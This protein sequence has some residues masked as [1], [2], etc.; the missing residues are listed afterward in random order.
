MSIVHPNTE[1]KTYYR[2][3]QNSLSKY[4]MDQA[5]ESWNTNCKFS[6][7]CFRDNLWTP[8]KRFKIFFHFLL[9]IPF[10]GLN[11]VLTKK[12]INLWIYM[13][14]TTTY[15]YLYF[16]RNSDILTKNLNY[17]YI[18]ESNTYFDSY[19]FTPT[20]FKEFSFFAPYWFF[21]L[22]AQIL[23]AALYLAISSKKSICALKKK[24]NLCAKLSIFNFSSIKVKCNLL[25][26]PFYTEF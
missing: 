7:L 8:Q 2:Y 22:F 19:R 25:M 11:I 3:K 15:Y 4:I 1:K 10:I 23:L 20:R 26:I 5:I 13:V 14:R 6:I 21:N 16:S 9:Q 12:F 18:N 17:K 24:D